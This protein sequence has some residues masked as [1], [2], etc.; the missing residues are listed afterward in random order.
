MRQ[1]VKRVPPATFTVTLLPFNVTLPETV[2]GVELEPLTAVVGV[3]VNNA[4]EPDCQFTFPPIVPVPPIGCATG[5]G[6]SVR[7]PMLPLTSNVPVLTVV[8][9][10]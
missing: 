1:A 9:P 4:D 5:R 2:S 3:S 10:V 8:L 7:A 6:H